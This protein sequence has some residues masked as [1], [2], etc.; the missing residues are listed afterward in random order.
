MGHYMMCAAKG[1]VSY[2]QRRGG[3]VAGLLTVP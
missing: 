3:S 2:S 1:E